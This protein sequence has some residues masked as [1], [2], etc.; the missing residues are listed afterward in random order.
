MFFDR[1][2]SR[3]K[4]LKEIEELKCEKNRFWDYYM[5]SRKDLCK[6]EAN[7]REVFATCISYNDD[8]ESMAYAKETLCSIL[9]KEIAP[10]IHIE[11]YRLVGDGWDSAVKYVSKV[12]IIE[13]KEKNY[14]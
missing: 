3:R 12:K 11:K 1:F 5:D 2:K 6:I 7:I 4:L 13:D 9:A 8:E 10:Y 14:Y